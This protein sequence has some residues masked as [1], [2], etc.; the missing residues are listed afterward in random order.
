MISKLSVAYFPGCSLHGVSRHVDKATK[1]VCRR[2]GIKLQ[3]IFDWNCCGATSAHSVDHDLNLVLNA[4]NLLLAGKTGT[5]LMTSPCAA[6]F[7]NLTMTNQAIQQPDIRTKLEDLL[8]EKLPE[9]KV[10]HLLEL[11]SEQEAIDCINQSMTHRFVNLKVACYYGCLI[12]R[13]SRQACFDDP[14]NPQSMDRLLRLCGADVVDWSHKAECC[15]A[16]FAVCA[17][18]IAAIRMDEILVQAKSTGADVITVAC[19]LCQSNLEMRQFARK[20]N[21][22]LP[23]VFVTQLIGLVLGLSPKEAGLNQLL[24]RGIPW[25]KKLRL[26]QRI[27][28]EN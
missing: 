6:C 24:Q 11:L 3:E 12:V 18:E 1:A 2:L 5:N 26:S 9:I 16:S 25:Q 17:P 10:V 21:I 27:E 15:G 19:P 13:P 22:N 20:D 4:R 14:E 23:V 7:S 8:D 28:E